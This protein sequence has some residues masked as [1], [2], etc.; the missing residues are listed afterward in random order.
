[1]EQTK[2][3]AVYWQVIDGTGNV[4]DETGLKEFDDET[5]ANAYFDS[6][7][8]SF[9]SILSGKEVAEHTRFLILDDK[10]YEPGMLV[11]GDDVKTRQINKHKKLAYNSIWRNQKSQSIT[12]GVDLYASGMV[13]KFYQIKDNKMVD[14]TESVKM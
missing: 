3:Y 9:P 11:Q 13:S 1:M 14:V 6:Q 10:S 4:A 5:A 7:L 2:K 8:A 12:N